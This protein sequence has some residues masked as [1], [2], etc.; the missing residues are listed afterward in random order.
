MKYLDKLNK[1]ADKF[2]RKLV[3]EAQL[4]PEVSQSGTTELF[5]GTE[6]NQVNFSNKVMK[7]NGPVFKVLN[8]FYAKTEKPCSFDLKMTA[9]PKKGASWNLTVNPATL[10]QA[11][12]NALDA[13]YKAMM[14]VSMAD[15]QKT[16]DAQAKAGGGSGSLAV[17]ALALD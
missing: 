11:V 7:V 15:R 13:E 16:A 3:K 9:E 14:K 12:Y 5:F 4:K 1:L 2:E 6:T 17:A 10:K 8:D